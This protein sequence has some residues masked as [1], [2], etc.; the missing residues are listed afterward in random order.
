MSESARKV[1]GT[2]QETIQAI[3]ASPKPGFVKDPDYESIRKAC[4]AL[5]TELTED[6][7][8]RREPPS[9]PAGA[10]G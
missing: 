6:L 8:S 3:L 9:V 5:R 2:V 7:L 4:S 10:G 1:Y